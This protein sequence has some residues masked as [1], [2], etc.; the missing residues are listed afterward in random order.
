MDIWKDVI[1]YEGIYEVSNLGEVRTALGKTTFTERHGVRNWKQRV[2]KQKTDN[3]GY[4]RVGLW[5]KG[6][7][8][9]VLVHRI[10]AEA[11][12][13][14]QKGKTIVNHINCDTS[15]NFASNLEWCDHKENLMHAFD[16]RLNK[17][18]NPIVLVEL[19][20][21]KPFYFRSMAEA[22]LFI[23]KSHGYLSNYIK[24]GN[25]KIEGYEIFTN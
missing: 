15:N 12:V 23:G 21:L 25:V 19:E 8:K 9:T 4:K 1:G 6:K 10:V 16:N 13:P 22:S 2:L 18:A 7:E 17:S 24:I 14:K 20:T 3:N 5:K 11:F